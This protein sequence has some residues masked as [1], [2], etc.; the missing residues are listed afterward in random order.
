MCG[1]LTQV[2]CFEIMCCTHSSNFLL[3]KSYFYLTDSCAEIPQWS[4][5]F[6]AA[7]RQ[8]T[9]HNAVV[10]WLD[11]IYVVLSISTRDLTIAKI[12]TTP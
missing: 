9:Q 5:L 3:K 8:C 4:P 10:K 11:L 1:L 6:T 2:S 12:N 7:V